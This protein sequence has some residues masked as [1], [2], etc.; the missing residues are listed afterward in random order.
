MEQIDKK[1]S[2]GFPLLKSVL[3][4]R[5]LYAMLI[6]GIVYLFI[7]KYIPL[8]GSVIA[9]KDY[10]IY[11][12]IWASDWV[13]F[14]YFYQFFN[15]PQFT[16]LLWNTLAISFY[17]TIFAFPAP[18]ILALLL[19]E[20]RNA[21]FKRSV[22]TI[23]YLPHFLSWVIIGGLGYMLMSPQVGL[24]N[25]WIAAFGFE[26]IHFLQ[27][28]GYFRSI[29]I[30]SGIWKEMGWNAIIF[31]AALAGIS[32]SLYEAAK[33]DG[34]GRWKQFLHITMPGILPAVMLLLLLKIGHTLDLGFEQIYIFLNPITYAT[35]DV[36][37]TYSY[38]EGIIQ[39]KYSM[40]TA[41]GLFKAVVGFLLLLMANRASK[42]LTGQGIF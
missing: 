20:L 32:P 26:K 25:Q 13:G 11:K 36:L 40:T 23:L 42:S 21:A 17:Q 28:P 31:L 24:I 8:F 6:P 27:E 35:G 41:I 39:G 2:P 12:G 5:I 7:F 22:Q 38:R 19:N 18:I 15:Y 30:T 34:A 14:K 10:N 33:I 29:I 37:D 3:K 1:H 16:R 9:F 4:H